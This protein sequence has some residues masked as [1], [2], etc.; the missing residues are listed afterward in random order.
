MAYF[1]E[2]SSAIDLTL[3]WIHGPWDTILKLN[4]AAKPLRREVVRL[5]D[6]FLPELTHE[7]N[8]HGLHKQLDFTS[9]GGYLKNLTVQHMQ[10][11]IDFLH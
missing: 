4:P 1:R 10:A 3:A 6:C 5:H 7:H 8:S 2:I 11:I 9:V